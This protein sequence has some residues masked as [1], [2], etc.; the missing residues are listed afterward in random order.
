MADVFATIIVTAA[1]AQAARDAA[2][3]VPGGE[4]MLTTGLSASGAEPATHYVS[5]GLVPAEIVQSLTMCDVSDLPPADAL[6]Q[7]GLKLC[8][9][10]D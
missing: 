9:P 10:S 5:S 7:A 3:Q 4:G 6:E 1:Q 8:A 2:A